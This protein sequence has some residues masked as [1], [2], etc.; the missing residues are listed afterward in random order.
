MRALLVNPWIYDF[1]AFDFWNKPLGLLTVSSILKKYGFTVDFIDCMDR[2]SPYFKTPT[3]TDGFGR[4]KYVSEEVEKPA[5]FKK[6]PR[7]YKRYG[8]PRGVFIEVLKKV[9]PPDIVFVTSSMTYWYPGVFEAIRILKEKFPK[10]KIVLGG[11]YATLCANH[12][13]KYSGAD[14]VIP[15]PAET[16]LPEYLKG[17]GFISKPLTGLEDIAPDFTL[18]PDLNYGVVLPSKGCPFSCT[19][20]ATYLLSP[21]FKIS[22]WPTVDGQLRYFSH[23]TKNIAFFDDALLCNK[24]FPELLKTAIKNNY[25][26]QLHS[27]NGLHCRFIDAGIAELMFRAG[28]K[29]VYL[30]LET[31]NPQAQKATGG[32]VFNAEFIRAVDILDKTGFSRKAI[33]AYLLFGLPG[34]KPE[35]I[36]R[37]IKFCR[38]LGVN[39]HLCEFSPIP[40][41]VEY[42]KTGF[43][44]KTDPLNHNNYFYT[45]HLAYPD[46]AVYRKMK[47]LLKEIDITGREI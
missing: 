12:A 31:T 6:I 30:S 13:V 3:R 10:P 33:R 9:T 14:R 42:E 8:M 34:Q 25:N 4:G 5:L 29:T 44:D 26:L 47:A 15:G 28:F 22:P 21:G 7:R 37:A 38:G 24:G 36:H 11:I 16:K 19:Y 41:T 17:E 27:S 45:W 40:H 23:R 43:G 35:E 39:P 1:K 46:P 32:K 2:A 18:Y 20:C